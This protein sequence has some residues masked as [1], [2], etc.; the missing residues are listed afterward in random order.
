MRC[1][2]RRRRHR[3][4]R[5]RRHH[6]RLHLHLRRRRPSPGESCPARPPRI[7]RLPP[8]GRAASGHVGN[9]ASAG[10]GDA[11]GGARGARVDHRP[12][13][14]RRADR[15]RARPPPLRPRQDRRADA[16]RLGLA[17]PGVG[18]RRPRRLRVRRGAARAWRTGRGGARRS[19]AST[20]GGGVQGV[21]RRA[22]A[23]PRVQLVRLRAA[24]RSLRRAGRRCGGRCSTTRRRAQRHARRRGARRR[25]AV[26]NWRN[27][28][29]E[30]TEMAAMRM[31][32]HAYA[33][34]FGA[35]L[36]R[37]AFSALTRRSLPLAGPSSTLAPQKGTTKSRRAVR[38]PP[39]L[40]FGRGASALTR[41]SSSD[42][43][44]P[45]LP[46]GPAALRDRS[47][48]TFEGAGT[49]PASTQTPSPGCCTC[50]CWV[51]YLC[52][53]A[54]RGP[55]VLG[56]RRRHA[57]AARPLA[58]ADAAARAA[59]AAAARA[60]DAACRAAAAARAAVAAVAAA[61]GAARA[62]VGAAPAAVAVAAA[63]IA[64]ATARAA[65]ASPPP[66]PSPPPATR[67][68]RRRRRRPPHPS[69]ASASPSPFCSPSF[70]SSCAIC[71][72]PPPKPPPKP[73][74]ADANLQT[75][76]PNAADKACG[77]S[78]GNE[79][80]GG[81][82]GRRAA[83]RT[84]R[85][86]HR[87]ASPTASPGFTGSKATFPSRRSR[88]SLRR[89]AP[90]RRRCPTSSR[91]CARAARTCR[92][93]YQRTPIP[94]RRPSHRGQSSTRRRAFRCAGR[95]RARPHGRRRVK[96]RRRLR[97]GRAAAAGP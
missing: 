92:G 81:E 56:H 48:Q 90:N 59:G 47:A 40:A 12:R 85:E 28:F 46:V 26:D 80:A 13:G 52:I 39:P 25:H 6:R 23:P 73:R 51:K 74:A 18:R 61:A 94:S 19:S 55:A 83:P 8:R 87:R 32:S 53:G 9:P 71:C 96:S 62:A 38:K 50:R 70:S 49:L 67:T 27:S 75:D 58:A 64:Q 63:A 5:R 22:A 34:K 78:A 69:T 20:G 60:A 35:I 31:R 88:Y 33:R 68:R 36:R 91:Y 21:G 1:H 95:R 72:R 10:G 2:N 15:R 11:R 44:T 16:G 37:R 66:P 24:P 30:V 65:D 89:R 97:G 4:R 57:A 41:R 77:A 42:G 45:R 84:G 93:S 82:T 29:T 79:A 7:S 86:E 54:R 76:P 17:L 14:R 43:A 3:R